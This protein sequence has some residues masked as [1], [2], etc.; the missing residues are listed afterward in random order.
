[1]SVNPSSLPNGF[2]GTAYNQTISGSGG[3]GPY[4]F[5]VSSGSLPNGLSLSSGGTLSGTPSAGGSFTFTVQGT[6]SVGNTGVRTYTVNIGTNSLTVNPSSLPNGTQS[7]PYSQTVTASGG[8]GPYTFALSSGSLPA[9]LSISSGG[10]IS[11]TPTGSGPSTFTVRATDSVANTGSQTYTI[12]IGSNILTVTPASLPNGT[13]GTAYS[14]TFGASGGTPP[15][16]T[17]TRTSGS[18]PPGLS[19]SSGGVLSGTPTAS[20]TFNFDVQASDP[21]FNTGTHSY[22]LTINPPPLTINP[23]SLPAATLGTAYNQTVT[24]SGGTRALQLQRAQ[25]IIADRASTLGAGSGAITGTPTVAGS[26]SFTIQATDAILTTGSRNYTINVGGNILIV[27]PPSLPNGTQGTAYSQTVSASG[28]TG[29]YSFALGI[30]RAAGGSR[31]QRWRRHQRHADRQRFVKFHDPRHRLAR[32]CRHRQLH[33]EYRH[34]RTDGKSA[35]RAGR[36][37]GHAL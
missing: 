4:T 11:G 14:Q 35:E 30:G 6:D 16:Y 1:M 23:S 9:G 26:Y 31:A 3:T 20:G 15:P 8:T 5:V 12:S 32:Q 22:S 34:Q 27:L 18:L 25:R 19:L 2:L 29:P 17:F 21:S 28:G 36:N 7:V 37:G 13:Q 10:V 33:R 24:A